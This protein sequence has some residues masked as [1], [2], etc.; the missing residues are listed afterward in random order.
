MVV[1]GIYPFLIFLSLYYLSPLLVIVIPWLI[2]EY[3]QEHKEELQEQVYDF[4]KEHISKYL[5]KLPFN[6]LKRIYTRLPEECA[7]CVKSFKENP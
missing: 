5:Q 6:T 7:I 4:N 2:F 3:Y 1:F